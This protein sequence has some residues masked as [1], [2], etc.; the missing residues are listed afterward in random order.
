MKNSRNK[1]S[2]IVAGIMLAVSVLVLVSCEGEMGP[3][4]PPGEPGGIEYADIY[5]IEGDFT[6]ANEYRMGFQFPGNGIFEDDVVLVYILWEIADGKDVWRLLPQTVVLKDNGNGETDVLQ[7]NFDFTTADVQVFL[8]FTFP[9][10]ELLPGET[11][12]QVFRI[13]VVP[14]KF[15][16]LKSVDVNDINTILEY[17][18]IDLNLHDKVELN[19]VQDIQI[20]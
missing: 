9:A 19:G 15:A 11:D 4:G 16:Q 8:E 3:M 17:P 1:L 13:A 12:N 5:E 14:S 20:K 7:Y 6:A 10:S 18:N 2:K